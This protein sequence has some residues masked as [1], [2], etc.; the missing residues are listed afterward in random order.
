MCQNRQRLDAVDIRRGVDTYLETLDERRVVAVPVEAHAGCCGA[1][2]VRF[3]DYRKPWIKLGT[4][5][6]RSHNTVSWLAAGSELIDAHT[7]LHHSGFTCGS[8]LVVDQD[9]FNAPI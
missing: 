1:D 8:R 3:R 2:M 7:A 9:N 4:V 5:F 6:D